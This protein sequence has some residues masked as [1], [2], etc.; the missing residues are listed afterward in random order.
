[1]VLDMQLLF[2]FSFIRLPTARSFI[3]SKYFTS[4]WLPVHFRLTFDSLPNWKFRFTDGEI[5]IYWKIP[6]PVF[7]WKFFQ[8]RAI[9]V[10]FNGWKFCIEHIHRSDLF[11]MINKIKNSGT[12]VEIFWCSLNLNIK[13]VTFIWITIKLKIRYRGCTLSRT[14]FTLL[15]YC[16]FGISFSKSEE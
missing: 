8:C 14:N 13:Q 9:L 2:E 12:G 1:M 11:W 6:V 16:R 10:N 5:S 7:F 3:I 4:G 15:T